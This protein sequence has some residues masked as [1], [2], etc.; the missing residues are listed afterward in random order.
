MRDTQRQIDSLRWQ[1]EVLMRERLTPAV[2]DLAGR[3]DTAMRRGQEQIEA[4]S[5]QVRD[6][7]LLAILVA[8]GTGYLLGRFLHR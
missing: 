1:V 6:R 3:A 7:P 2:T 4:V 8:V 5:G